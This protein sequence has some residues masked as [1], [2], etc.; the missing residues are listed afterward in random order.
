M[1]T[2]A[3]K[4]A[5]LRPMDGGPSKINPPNSHPLNPIHKQTTQAQGLGEKN[6]PNQVVKVKVTN[7]EKT[8]IKKQTS[9]APTQTST[10][11]ASNNTTPHTH[12]QTHTQ[13][14]GIM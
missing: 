4:K 12:T 2:R 3:Q 13:V 11:T 14:I 1:L 8:T 5:S 7:Q 6:T 9:I 10:I